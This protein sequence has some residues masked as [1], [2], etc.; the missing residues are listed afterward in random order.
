ML[1]RALSLMFIAWVLGFLWF[2]VALPQPAGAGRADGVV[3]L[4]E[5][6]LPVAAIWQ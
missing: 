2:A 4:T 6:A 3:V 5:Q 1:A